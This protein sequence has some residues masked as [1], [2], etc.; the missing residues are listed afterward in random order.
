MQKSIPE[1]DESVTKATEIRQ[2]QHAEFVT[3]TANNEVATELIKLTVIKSNRLLVPKTHK[4]APNANLNSEDHVYVNVGSEI[5]TAAYT[6]ATYEGALVQV[7]SELKDAEPPC[8][9]AKEVLASAEELDVKAVSTF[10]AEDSDPAASIVA[11]RV[12]RTDDESSDL[13]ANIEVLTKAI[14]A[15]VNVAT[16]SSFFQSSSSFIRMLTVSSNKV[17]DEDRDWS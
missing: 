16:E 1:L 6:G 11:P 2:K 13:V 4:N 14:A 7:K 15:M 17:P 8:A 12:L 3:P 9:E 5:I 10:D